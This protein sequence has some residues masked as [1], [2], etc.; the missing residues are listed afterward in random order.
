M[1][2]RNYDKPVMG[3]FIS[4]KEKGSWLRFAFIHFQI[5]SI[6][7]SFTSTALAK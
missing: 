5:E 6:C 4:Y 2:L 1:K 7:L 3:I